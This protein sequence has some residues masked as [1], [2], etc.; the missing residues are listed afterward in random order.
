MPRLRDSPLAFTRAQRTFAF[1]LLLVGAVGWSTPHWLPLV[2]PARAPEALGEA[3]MA[4]YR[5]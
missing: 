3:E 5:A 1:A 2:A 4:A